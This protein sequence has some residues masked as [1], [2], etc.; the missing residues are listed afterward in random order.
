MEKSAFGTAAQLLLLQTEGNFFIFFLFF[1]A[2]AESFL[3]S[4][5]TFFRSLSLSPSACTHLKCDPVWLGLLKAN[6]LMENQSPESLYI[7]FFLTLLQ[8]GKNEK[9]MLQLGNCISAQAN[10][11]CLEGNIIRT[12]LQNSKWF[13]SFVGG[14]FKFLFLLQ[15]LRSILT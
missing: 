15:I 7:Y 13:G 2:P 6:L 5:F 3:M 8:A 1:A 10:D 14:P 9:A 11:R 4:N 12:Q